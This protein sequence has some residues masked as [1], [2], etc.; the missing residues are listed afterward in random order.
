MHKRLVASAAAAAVATLLVAAAPATAAGSNGSAQLKPG[1]KYVALGSSFASGPAIPEVADAACLRSSNDYPNLVARKLKLAL[2]DV[3]CGSA[4]TDSI[5][6]QNQKAAPPQIEAV[7]P[8]TKLVT[9][10]IG[11]NDVGYTATNLICS[12]DAGEGK[13][14]LGTD[15][16][17]TD[18]ETNLA[19]L[20]AKLDATLQAIKDA[21]PNATIV[22]LPYLRVL[23]AV[24]T[25]CPP[26]VP[27][28]TPTLSYL[29]GFSDKLHTA[30]KDAATRAKVMFVD[31][32]RPKGHDACA[33]EASRWVE[34][35][36]PASPAFAFHPNAAGMK[37][38][39]KMIVAALT[40]RKRAST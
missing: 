4:T 36:Q 12:G 22:V 28:S 32:Y 14:C 6:T 39:A 3:S 23:P 37:A 29:E 11:G 2:T 27:M 19:A 24:A 16:Q 26:S 17:P 5:L 20:P 1:D 18:I 7:T 13:E 38:Q 8:D 35:A 31:S 33:S 21:A 25:P 40:A 9:V 15:V 34:G 10:T 30:I